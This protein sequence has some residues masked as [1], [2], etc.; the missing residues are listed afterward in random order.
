M[1]VYVKYEKLLKINSLINTV[2]DQKTISKVV[3]CHVQLGLL[4]NMI[5][6][7][8]RIQHVNRSPFLADKVSEHEVD[9]SSPSRTEVKMSWSYT[10]N[11]PISLQDNHKD[12]SISIMLPVK[13]S[14]S[15]ALTLILRRSC[16]GTVW[17]YTST[18]NKRAA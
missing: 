12:N 7:Q 11:P 3:T 6:A 8:P 13:H 14:V 16:T 4:F 10:S 17:F 2:L 1:D 15:T 5:N 18:S 9:H